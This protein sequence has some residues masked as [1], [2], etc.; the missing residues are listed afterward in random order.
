M[1]YGLTIP[2]KRAKIR[3]RKFLPRE[4]AAV[5]ERQGGLCACGCKEP[6]GA[7]PRDIDYDHILPLSIGGRDAPDNLQALK[8]KHHRAKSNRE[9][10]ER[11]KADRIA[12]TDGHRRRNL[13]VAERELAA[14][15]EKESP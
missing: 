12:A 5:I 1:G 4:Y 8:R 14:L 2:K 15:I 6:L 10:T 9:T 3:R 11:A 13:S 7:D